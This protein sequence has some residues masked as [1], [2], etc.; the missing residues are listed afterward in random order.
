MHA[1]LLNIRRK[2]PMQE[3]RKQ[4]LQF[5]NDTS[6]VRI[7]EF[8]HEFQDKD[9]PLHSHNDR[10][11]LVYLQK[12]KANLYIGKQAVKAQSG[13]LLVYGMDVLHGGSYRTSERSGKTERFVLELQGLLL[14]GLSEGQLLP[15][16]FHPIVNLD[17]PGILTSMFQLIEREYLT[18][19][20][21]WEAVCL[22][23]LE[24]LFQLIRRGGQPV[25]CVPQD[26]TQ[27]QLLADDIL[28]FVHTHYCEK[29]SLQSI[30]DYFYISPYY[31]SHLFKEQRN[32]SLMQYV[33]QLR[34]SEAQMLL[35]DTDYS[36][37]QIAQMMGYQNFNYFLNVFKKKTGTTPTAYRSEHC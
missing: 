11:E 26:K 4:N 18:Q 30:A 31:L 32:I 17:M 37:R 8:R 5:Y 7:C 20:D 35:R 10:C 1:D 33:V 3:F 23:M 13:A 19:E 2:E 25:Q 16:G 21:G 12:G 34:I 24:A 15:P 6:S 29:I 36:V 14:D 27:V 28:A 22:H 9:V